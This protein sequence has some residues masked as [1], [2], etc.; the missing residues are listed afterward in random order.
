[1]TPLRMQPLFVTFMRRRFELKSGVGNGEMFVEAGL[2][3]VKDPWCVAA[4]KA[5][6]IHHYV[7]RQ[8]RK[9]RRDRPGVQVV[10]IEHVAHL[11]QV[12]TN[13]V[14]IKVVGRPLE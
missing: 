9:V 13:V 3:G 12:S 6:I 2:Q 14:K 1:M 4:V 8:R 11:Y 5:A 10:N 7:R